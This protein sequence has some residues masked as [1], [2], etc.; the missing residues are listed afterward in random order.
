[1]ALRKNYGAAK[2]RRRRF[3]RGA[4]DFTGCLCQ[5]Q[6]MPKKR[7]RAAPGPQACMRTAQARSGFLKQI[8]III[9]SR[10]PSTSMGSAQS[11]GKEARLLNAVKNKS[12]ISPKQIQK[13]MDKY[14]VD[15]NLADKDGRTAVI[16]AR[17]SSAGGRRAVGGAGAGA[18]QVA[19][20]DLAIPR[21]CG[22][23][24]R[25]SAPPHAH[26]RTHTHTH[27]KPHAHVPSRD[28]MRRP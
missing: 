2:T 18:G 26:R 13:Y 24:R 19:P 6:P 3:S 15:V 20:A 22:V 8:L 28:A 17:G 23:S 16:W 5:S 21:G 12:S 27:R 9:A 10:A 1:M 4:A 25:G 11:G 14:A 7:A